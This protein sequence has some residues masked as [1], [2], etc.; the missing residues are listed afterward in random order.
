LAPERRHLPPAG[1]AR[2]VV[3]ELAVAVGVLAEPF[4]ERVAEALLD[5]VADDVEPAEVDVRR[6]AAGEREHERGA[7][8]G[9]GQSQAAPLLRIEAWLC[10]G[11]GE[12]LARDGTLRQVGIVAL[13]E[14]DSDWLR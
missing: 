12:D 3:A 11:E 14:R 2:L 10:A 5:V 8:T 6:G 4:V 13:Q 7:A 9:A 1:P